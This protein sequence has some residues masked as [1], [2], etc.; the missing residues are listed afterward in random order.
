LIHG[1]HAVGKGDLEVVVPVYS[2]DELGSLADAFNKMV[3]ALRESRNRLVERA[4]TDGLTDLYNHRHFQERLATEISRSQR[5]DRPLS[6]IMLDIDQFKVL[7]DT[8]GHPIGDVVLQEIAQIL[9]TELRDIDVV[10]RYGG[11]EFALILP[12]TI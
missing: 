12:E 4:N 2:C 11:E 3:V 10:A 6:V 9:I 1:A 5:F 7:N 8:H